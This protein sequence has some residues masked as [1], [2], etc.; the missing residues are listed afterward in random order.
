MTRMAMVLG[1]WRECLPDVF[2]PGCVTEDLDGDGVGKV[3][4]QEGLCPWKG[5]L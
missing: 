1:V 3:G 5:G 2:L 4:E